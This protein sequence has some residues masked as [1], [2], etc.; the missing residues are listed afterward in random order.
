MDTSYF[1]A[2]DPNAAGGLSPRI[3]QGRDAF[4]S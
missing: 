2:L 3:R 1:H 4:P